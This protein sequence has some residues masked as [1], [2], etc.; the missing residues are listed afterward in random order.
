MENIT[1]SGASSASGGIYNAI[2]MSGACKITSDTE[3]NVFKCS[4]ASKVEGNLRCKNFHASG[5]S[6][7]A[8]RVECE[9]LFKC[10]GATSVGAIHAENIHTSGATKSRGDVTAEKLINTSGGLTVEGNLTSENIS[11]SGALKVKGNIN[12][13]NFNFDMSASAANSSADTIGGAT[14]R[15]ARKDPEYGIFN[16]IINSIFN[17]GNPS[18]FTVDEIEGDKISLQGVHARVV[19]GNDVNIGWDCKIGRVEYTGKVTFAENAEIG[20]LVEI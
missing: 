1:L 8:G 10:S 18:V 7:V 9:Q 4:G 3:C 19:R 16:S 2:T 6:D 5:A 11:G 14:I 17:N 20:E 15:I 12:A 13:E